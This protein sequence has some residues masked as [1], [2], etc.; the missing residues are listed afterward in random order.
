M[1]LRA[2]FATPKYLTP[3]TGWPHRF[4]RSVAQTAWGLYRFILPSTARRSRFRPRGNISTSRSGPDCQRRLLWELGMHVEQFSNS[5]RTS[6][7]L[8]NTLPISHLP[9]VG[10]PCTRNRAPCSFLSHF[11]A[12]HLIC[13]VVAV[14]LFL[15]STCTLP[16]EN[17]RH[18]RV[19]QNCG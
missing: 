17:V 14:D 2:R 8:I 7:V 1:F 9:L 4:F 12:T 13:T 18:S 11:D 5:S 15:N 16:R 6:K 10:Q 3:L 19:K